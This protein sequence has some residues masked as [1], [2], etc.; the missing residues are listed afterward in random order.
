MLNISTAFRQKLYDDEREYI[1]S[2]VITLSD[3]TVLNV[4]NAH[5]MSNGFD[6]E[7]A[8]SEDDNFTVLG[9]TIINA[10]TLILYNNDEVY[11]DYDFTNAKCVLYT[12]MNVDTVVNNEQTTIPESIKK[13]TFTV[14]EA[15]Y[16]NATITL[17]LLDNM[18]QFDRP[19][20]LSN[21]VYPATLSEIVNDACSI[22]DVRL[23]TSYA[24][25]PHRDYEVAERPNGE[26]TT[27]REVIGWVATIAGCYARC[28]VNG[29]LE[30]KWFNISDFDDESSLDGGKFNPWTA[31][32]ITNGGTFSPWTTGDITGGELFTNKRPLHYITALYTQSIAVD[33]TVITG[34]RITVKIE[35]TESDEDMREFTAGTSDY[36][37][38]IADNPFITL[39]TAP[40]VLNWISTLLV[41]LRFRKCSVTQVSDPSMEAGDLG[42]LWDTK[43]VEHPILI[44]RTSFS[45]TAPQ[46]VVCG[47]DTPSRNSATRFTQQTKSYVEARKQ[48]REQRDHYQAAMNDLR[49]DLAKANGLY[50]TEEVQQDQS[51]IYHFHEKPNLSDSKIDIELST[52]GITVTP[53]GGQHIYG[54]K[55]DGQF[56]ASVINTISLF[57]D[58]AHGGTLKLGGSG[59]GNGIL[60]ILD[61]GGNEIGRM[62]NTGAT[63]QG[64]LKIDYSN[65]QLYVGD[66]QVHDVEYAG[67]PLKT[68]TGLLLKTAVATVAHINKLYNNVS[69]PRVYTIIQGNQPYITYYQWTNYPDTDAVANDYKIMYAYSC[70]Q[71][72]HPGYFNMQIG[73]NGTEQS[74]NLSD[75][76]NSTVF[77][78]YKDC[79]FRMNRYAKLLVGTPTGSSVNN[80]DIEI[81]NCVLHLINANLEMGLQSDFTMDASTSL[82]IT[83][84]G[85]S[86]NGYSIQLDSTSSKRYK[87]DIEPLKDDSLNPHRLY[88]LN[89]VQY[90]YNEDAKLQYAD[91]KGQL[92]PGFIAEEVDEIYPSAVIHSDGKVESWD[93]RRIVPGMLQLIQEQHKQIEELQSKVDRLEALV[94]KLLQER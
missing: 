79:S 28:N 63:I 29:E 7:D 31:G 21:L 26:S 75:D 25:F 77:T 85:G 35:D 89:V 72:S 67:A 94:E 91:M 65:N 46:T 82:A 81:G 5:I 27:F 15:T 9:S 33:D 37:I 80:I 32:T 22:C 84:S 43:G 2:A 39:D 62:D 11:S 69:Y 42:I 55:I 88:Q 74:I 17:S 23:S 92:L 87:H 56:L 53:D 93:E 58:N 71:F 48:L 12:G 90:R 19:Y 68:Y 73:S 6:T 4:D 59:N 78:M 38:D 36:R 34:V 51:V 30:L 66:I 14:D 10:A 60:R 1:N 52:V 57:F 16:N 54:L 40:T 64:N 76:Y 45:P 47:S 70:I 8:I 20:S 44:T 13:G 86:I 41:G 61:S 83:S 24:L 18:E 3:G 49:G 50:Y